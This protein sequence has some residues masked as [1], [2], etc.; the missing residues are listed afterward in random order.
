[1][2]TRA[3]LVGA[4]VVSGAAADQASRL[5]GHG[6]LAGV[7]VEMVHVILK[8]HSHIGSL[9]LAAAPRCCRHDERMKRY[10]ACV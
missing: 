10:R 2:N 4:G 8:T 7:S 5:F 1:M 9:N 3:F 6:S